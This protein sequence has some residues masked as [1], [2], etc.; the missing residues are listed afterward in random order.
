MAAYVETSA[1]NTYFAERL[2][3]DIWTGATSEDKGKA[4]AQATR[5]INTLNFTSSKTDSSQSNEFPRGTGGITPQ[6]VLDA[7]C[8]IAYELLD[9]FDPNIEQQNLSVVSQ[10]FVSA[11]TVSDKPYMNAYLIAGVPSII[12][13]SLLL[14]YLAQATNIKLHRVS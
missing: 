10:G 3:S 4:L 14:P 13:W 6:A 7:C 8:E 5:I 12:A 9:G 2:R 11:R 1:A